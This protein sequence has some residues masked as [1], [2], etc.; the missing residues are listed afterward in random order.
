MFLL[1]YWSSE[2]KILMTLLELKFAVRKQ[3]KVRKKLI[4]M[5]SRFRL[6]SAAVIKKAF[7][8]IGLS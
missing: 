7:S 4:T 8:Q 3:E 2:W 6:K 1:K 5:A